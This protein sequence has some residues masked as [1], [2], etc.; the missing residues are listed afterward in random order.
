[1]IQIA[2]QTTPAEKNNN[3]LRTFLRDQNALEIK[4]QI[5]KENII[6]LELQK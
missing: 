4:R 6:S 5:V 3:F 2:D 1:M